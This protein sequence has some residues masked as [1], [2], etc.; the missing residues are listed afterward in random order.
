M[1]LGDIY[2][3]LV[4]MAGL[5]QLASCGSRNELRYR[6]PFIGSCDSLLVL[7]E[8]HVHPEQGFSVMV[9]DSWVLTIEHPDSLG[10]KEGV[11]F[12][13][14][15]TLGGEKMIFDSLDQIKFFRCINITQFT[16]DGKTL[17]DQHTLEMKGDLWK[18]EK[19]SL[20]NTGRMKLRT[21]EYVWT[22]HSDASDIGTSHGIF[23]LTKGNEANHY[24]ILQL[25]FY[26]EHWER[27]LCR[28]RPVLESFEF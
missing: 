1:K 26:G 17:L 13:A 27:E 12:I 11:G 9:P 23:F 18:D 15:L 24:I 19:I 16:G 5:L 3:M 7:T 8:R 4:L 2:L 10:I 20:V 14:G 25:G 22:L 21:R 28:M 6:S